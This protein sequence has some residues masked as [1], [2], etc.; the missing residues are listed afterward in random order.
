MLNTAQI[1]AAPFAL[2]VNEQLTMLDVLEGNV[3]DKLAEEK[4][5]RDVRIVEDRLAEL[6]IGPGIL[7]GLRSR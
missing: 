5:R 3:I 4:R 2:P 6:D 7:H 1:Q